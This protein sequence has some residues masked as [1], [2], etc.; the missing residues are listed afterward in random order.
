MFLWNLVDLARER[1]EGDTALSP[2]K[3]VLEFDFK[4]DGMGAGT[5]AFNNLSGIG[6]SGTG[7]LKVDGKVVAEKRDGAHHPLHPAMGRES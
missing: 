6:Q 1:W 7:T 5:L 4:Y 2:G 3:H